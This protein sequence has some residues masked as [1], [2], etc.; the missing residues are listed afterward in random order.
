MSE[1]VLL[2]N[3]PLPITRYSPLTE[4]RDYQEH[5]GL[6][7][8][9]SVLRKNGID[10]KILDAQVQSFTMDELVD[11]IINN[12][13]RV[14][15]FSLFH[16]SVNIL[17]ELCTRI[18]EKREDIHLTCGGHFVTAT[19]DQIL[20]RFSTLDSAVSGEGELTL[21]EL[22]KAILNESDWHTV[23]GLAYRIKDQIL[24]SP[25]RDLIGNL[26]ILPF[27]DRD[28]LDHEVAKGRKIDVINIYS[29]RGCYGTCHFCSIK[30]FYGKK[31][32]SWRLRS[33]QNVVDE[34]EYLQKKY[35]PRMFNF[36][37]DNFIGIGPKGKSRAMQIAKEI[38]KRGLKIRFMLS[39]RVDDV[40]SKL[41]ALLKQAGLEEV[42]LGIE[43]FSQPQ[44][45]FV[46][47]L[48]GYEENCK[49]IE[50]L[51]NMNLRISPGFIMFTPD[52]RLVDIMRNLK[53]LER[54]NLLELDKFTYLFRVEG[55]A[56][57]INTESVR[58]KEDYNIFTYSNMYRR[59]YYFNDPQTTK[60]V[61]IL[62]KDHWLLKGYIVMRR[63]SQIINTLAGDSSHPNYAYH[64]IVERIDRDF[65]H[66]NIQY[67]K[68]LISILSVAH[69]E[70]MDTKLETIREEWRKRER[71]VRKV[72]HKIENEISICEG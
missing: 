34:L 65:L 46:N 1:Q 18:K 25:D 13:Y 5:L 11:E 32:K 54:Y 23:P 3:L 6:E 9:A 30:T 35:Q 39:C 67:V 8:L 37:D 55:S 59:S 21:T 44:L 4:R 36:V 61:E 24:L 31:G 50:L 10:V 63:Y 49:T 56:F 33:A 62:D 66:I 40:N 53:F 17:G 42:F 70:M 16:F 19:Y 7:S 52:T 68:D 2:I 43:S 72:L 14:V 29:S 69:S 71:M 12:H 60:L 57:S 51:Q 38:R 47:K 22:V 41:F 58:F 27:P 26:D 20:N 15:G 45:N 64:K 28:F 48:V